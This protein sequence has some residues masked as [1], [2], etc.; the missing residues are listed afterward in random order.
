M[1]VI[2]IMINPCLFDVIFYVGR[3][4]RYFICFYIKNKINLLEGGVLA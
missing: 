2:Y 4:M 1:P 3:V